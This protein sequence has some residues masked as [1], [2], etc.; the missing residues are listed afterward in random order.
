[1]GMAPS[2]P[3]EG[4]LGNRLASASLETSTRSSIDTRAPTRS[5][6]V[7]CVHDRTT[8]LGDRSMDITPI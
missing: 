6:S 4:L 7:G 3:H 1:M 2:P 8:A 5:R